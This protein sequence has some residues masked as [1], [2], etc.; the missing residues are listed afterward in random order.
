MKARHCKEL[1]GTGPSIGE[2]VPALS[3][4]G[5]RLARALAS[6]LARLSGGD[7]PVVRVGMPLDG[8]LGSI[9]SELEGL[10]SHT[11]LAVGAESRPMLAVFEAAPVFR[12]V[13]RAFGG[14]GDVPDPLPDTFPLS[15]EL[16]IARIEGTVADALSIAFGG[17]AKHTVRT[18]R[19]ETSLRQLAPFDRNE[20]LLLLSLEVEETGCEPWSMLLAFPQTTLSALVTVP[21]HPRKA[22]MMQAAPDPASE[23]FASMPLQVKAVLVDMTMGFSRL[24][25]LK[26]GDILPVAV[27]RSVPLKVGDRT[28]ANGTIGELDDRVAVQVSHA[29]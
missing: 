9:Q 23:P 15:A 29:F 14:R 13:D 5:E 1:L 27:A 26:P 7:A 25:S 11:L 28:V 18:V 20:E 22:R 19:R 21:R 12:L 3:L 16:L 2:L 8:T 17:E 10:A 6:G 4:I 24:S